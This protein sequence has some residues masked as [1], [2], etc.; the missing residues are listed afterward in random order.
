MAK[1]LV[2]IIFTCTVWGPRLAKHHIQFSPQQNFSG[3]THGSS[4]V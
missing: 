3:V 4:P 2:P 1:E